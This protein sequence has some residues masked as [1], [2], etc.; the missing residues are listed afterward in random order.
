M[1]DDTLS[2]VGFDTSR[3]AK[4][5]LSPQERFAMAC[6]NGTIG[7]GAPQA[8]FVRHVLL[9]GLERLGW[10]EEM[11]IQQYAEYRIRCLRRGEVN[12]FESE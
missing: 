12:P 2:P 6:A 7:N 1:A 9:L 4:T 5:H 3:I 8:A 10:N 11:M